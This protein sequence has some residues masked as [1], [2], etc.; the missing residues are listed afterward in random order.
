VGV[1]GQHTALGQPQADLTAG[2]DGRIEVDA[3]PQ[4]QSAHSRHAVPDH[5]RQAGV[6]VPAEFG[7]PGLEFATLQHAD[8]RGA[9]GRGQRIAAERRSVLA[10]V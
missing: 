10:G 1:L 5:R 8:H 2:A 9:D 4:T 7:C 3:R 6:Q